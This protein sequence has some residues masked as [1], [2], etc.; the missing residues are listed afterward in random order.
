MNINIK[1][2]AVTLTPAITSYVN[3]RLAKIASFLEDDTTA[4]CDIELGKTTEHHQK[5]NIFRAEIHIVAANKNAYASSE[6]RDLYT[7]IDD[8]RDEILRELKTDKNKRISVIR[9]SGARLKNMVKGLW[10]WRKRPTM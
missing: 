10:P 1:T 9:R 6:Q 3:K 7:A 8:V 4:Q 2:T 5:G